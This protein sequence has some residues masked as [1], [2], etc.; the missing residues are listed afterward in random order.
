MLRPASRLGPLAICLIYVALGSLWILLSDRVVLALWGS[1]AELL[2]KVSIAKGWGY[3]LGS[4]SL[5]YTLVLRL[6]RVSLRDVA[7]LR[8]AEERLRAS[9]GLFH[10]VARLAPVVIFRCDA[11]GACIYVNEHWREVT[12]TP[13]HAA[14][15]A[16]WVDCVHPADRD[17]VWAEWRR[18]V[19]ARSPYRQEFRFLRPGQRVSWVLARVAEEVDV[20]GAL[21]GYVGTLTD[22][23]ER[24][25]ADERN[26]RHAEELERRVWERTEQ[27]EASSRE[28]DA[29]SYTVSHDLRAP[30]RTVS[31]F[32]QMVLQE[33]ADA[34]PD[35]SKGHLRRVVAACGRMGE[36]IDG[37]LN[38][39]RV[40]RSDLRSEWVDVTALCELIGGEL[41]GEEPA[42]VVQF[43]VAPD[44]R[45]W[46]DPT[47]LGL[48]LEN[49]LRNAWKFTRG[50]EAARI[51]VQR[52]QAADSLEAGI[53]V[54]DN[55]AGFDMVWAD[56]LFRAFERLH[57]IE[58]FPGTGIGLATVHRIVTRHGGRVWAEGVVG[59]GASFAFTVAPGPM[60]AM[61]EKA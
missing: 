48:V 9:E 18:C 22:I 28:L 40:T 27:L 19:E 54:R 14:L 55:G 50:T 26:Q 17:A 11:K 35:A 43:D 56:K 10:T 31:G 25:E 44:L 41:R 33:G 21:V 36:I 7:V 8:R 49:L 3:V 1:D 38:L 5:L 13:T 47:L 6:E 23:T 53:V 60:P 16:G 39:A 58:E 61:P 42:R 15:E 46:G 2:T 59:D 4:G 29:F 34:L 20:D 52:V 30:L 45:L 24:K 51:V 32:S 37:L 57:T 12:A